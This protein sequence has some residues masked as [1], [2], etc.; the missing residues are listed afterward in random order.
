MLHE[1]F[2]Y[3]EGITGQILVWLERTPCVAAVVTGLRMVLGWAD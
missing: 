2:L 1:W 3:I